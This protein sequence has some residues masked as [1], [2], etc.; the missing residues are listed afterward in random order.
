VP[1]KAYSRSVATGYEVV[2]HGIFRGVTFWDIH[3]VVHLY[4]LTQ[5]AGESDD[6]EDG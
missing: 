4:P 6:K 1:F 3:S 2:T 5:A